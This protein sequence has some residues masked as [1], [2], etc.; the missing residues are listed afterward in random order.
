MVLRGYTFC[1]SL[2]NILLEA[3]IHLK[4][5]SCCTYSCITSAHILY[6]NCKSLGDIDLS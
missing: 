5:S 4:V 1:M 2:S 3:Y 6:L